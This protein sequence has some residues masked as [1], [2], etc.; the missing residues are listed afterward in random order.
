QLQG[1]GFWVT[2]SQLAQLT[3]KVGTSETDDL[4]VV[5]FDGKQASNAASFH[6]SATVAGQANLPPAVTINAMDVSA[7]P[8]QVLQASALFSAQ[9]GD[10]DALTYYITDNSPAASS[11]PSEITGVAQIQG[12]GF[13]VT[14]SQLAQ[15]TFR[16]GTSGT[17]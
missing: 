5:A 2:Q 11:G 16:A 15:L 13:W 4:S 3:F 17:D 1:D 12:E 9:D 10:N 6:V 14:Q 7:S 8:G